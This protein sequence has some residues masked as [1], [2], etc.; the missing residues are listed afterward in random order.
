MVYR[1]VA[2]LILGITGSVFV[3]VIMYLYVTDSGVLL[4]QD[5]SPV[6][7]IN[8][9]S[10][11]IHLPFAVPETCLV[12]RSILPYEGPFLED[13]SDRE[14]VDVA[15]ILLQ[16]VGN[17]D[18]LQCGVSIWADDRCFEFY[19]EYIPS[20]AVV[21][22]LER[23]AKAFVPLDITD[24]TGWQVSRSPQ[25]QN[26]DALHIVEKAM[27]TLF[28]SNSS[29]MTLREVQIT[30]KTWLEE[31]DILI[32]GISYSVLI[33]ALDPGQTVAIYPSHYAYG[34]SKIVSVT[35]K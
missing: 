24:C 13:A 17:Q 20:Q 35:W 32:G 4:Y 28:V 21:L 9:D 1:R 29:I 33:E 11:S 25:N 8:A 26:N 6:N 23:N 34:Y 16:N 5:S 12:V 18:L 22:L 27:G 7:V 10:E 19:G 31:E 30:Y 14:M 3:G 15:A 2:L